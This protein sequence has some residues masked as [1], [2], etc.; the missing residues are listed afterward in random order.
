M[1][2]GNAGSTYRSDS[3]DTTVVKIFRTSLLCVVATDKE[4][5]VCGNIPVREISCLKFTLWSA[6]FPIAF[7]RT[8]S[9]KTFLFFTTYIWPLWTCL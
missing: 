6:Y 2:L 4:A 5:V 1:L 3:C 7:L 8:Q 9:T